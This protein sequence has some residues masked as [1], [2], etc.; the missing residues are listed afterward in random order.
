[1]GIVNKRSPSDSVFRIAKSISDPLYARLKAYNDVY[2]KGSKQWQY[3]TFCRN[4]GEWS[5]Q[6]EKDAFPNDNLAS[7]KY[8]TLRWLVKSLVY[9]SEWEGKAYYTLLM[10]VLRSVI[11]SGE[12]HALALSDEAV[13]LGLKLEYFDSV[14]EVLRVQRQLADRLLPSWKSFPIL[15]R[16]HQLSQDVFAL[17]SEVYTW[18]RHAHELYLPIKHTREAGQPVPADDLATL[19]SILDSYLL[20]DLRSVSAKRQ[21]LA[22]SV[23][24]FL[25]EKNEVKALEAG[26]QLMALYGQHLWLCERHSHEF[27]RNAIGSSSL[28][29]T[30]GDHAFALACLDQ[31]QTYFTRNE[32]VL[33]EKTPYL[34]Y[35][36]ARRFAITHRTSDIEE[37]IKLYEENQAVLLRCPD[38]SLR[39]WVHFFVGIGAMQIGRFDIGQVAFTVLSYSKESKRTDLATHSRVL[40]LLCLVE[41]PD[42]NLEYLIR[43]C[44]TTKTYLARR[45]DNTEFLRILIRDLRFALAHEDWSHDIQR[46]IDNL[47]M[48]A[49][50]EDARSCLRYF[51][52]PDFLAKYTIR[53]K[54]HQ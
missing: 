11:S 15:E 46:C 3:F 28:A 21:Y 27:Y 17:A 35:A 5:G 36:A 25:L 29:Y 32:G 51:N 30:Q 7:L 52:Y 34:I 24:R 53:P 4:L 38:G 54:N 13:A 42:E 9:L 45:K 40:L 31:L 41:T 50:S 44:E 18:E 48:V 23:P 39:E 47:L 20:D 26:R 10:E 43:I 16:N 49:E 19:A 14:Q 12:H 1:M 8:E 22:L 2:S 33:E 6:V 37:A